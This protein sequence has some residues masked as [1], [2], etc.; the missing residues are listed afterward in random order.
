MGMNRLRF[1]EWRT[2]ESGALSGFI[3]PTDRDQDELTDGS[4]RYQT[5]RQRSHTSLTKSPRLEHPGES[6]SSSKDSE[7][8]GVAAEIAAPRTTDDEE[9][10]SINF[11][12]QQ[13]EV[14]ADLFN[15]DESTEEEELY[16]SW[17]ILMSLIGIVKNPLAIEMYVS[18]LIHGKRTAVV[19]RNEVVTIETPPG[20]PDRCTKSNEARL[21]QDNRQRYIGLVKRASRMSGVYGT[22]LLSYPISVHAYYM[23]QSPIEPLG[24]TSPCPDFLT[25]SRQHALL[26]TSIQ[27]LQDMSALER[28]RDSYHYSIWNHH[29]AHEAFGKIGGSREA[30][31]EMREGISALEEEQLRRR[32]LVKDS[33]QRMWFGTKTA[34]KKAL[35]DLS[36]HSQ[37]HGDWKTSIP[38]LERELATWKVAEEDKEQSLE[39]HLWDSGAEVEMIDRDCTDTI[40]Y[41]PISIAALHH[42]ASF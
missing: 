40:P 39:R 3:V 7:F 8:S 42:H 14:D 25:A 28:L 24:A 36:S 2:F 30:I 22:D 17:G 32:A 12:V 33:K 5:S 31:K 38:K 11:N 41:S 18:E 10:R 34:F 35:E 19:D 13:P 9:S 15:E 29:A 1:R 27:Q 6:P 20:W 21:Y 16:R 37:S 23:R 26:Q 4:L